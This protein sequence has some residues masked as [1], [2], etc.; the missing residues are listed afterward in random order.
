[1]D[2]QP[3][4]V[5]VFA[6]TFG[7]LP[8]DPSATRSVHLQ[9]SGFIWSDETPDLLSVGASKGTSERRLKGYQFGS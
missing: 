2:F 3:H 4:D 6:D 1:M 9:A 5:Y 8:Y 7:A